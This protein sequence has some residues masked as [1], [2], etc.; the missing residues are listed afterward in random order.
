M[1]S[2]IAVVRLLLDP[3]TEEMAMFKHLLVPIDFSEP[4][5]AA[6]DYART[7]ATQFGASLHLLHVTEDPYRAFYSAE[8]YV[9]EV[10]GLREE[11][12]N[13]SV[14][15]LKGLLRTSDLTDLHAMAEAVIGT[16]ASTI[17]EYAA[18]RGIDLIVMGTH[19]RGG[20]SHLLLGS[21][22]ERVV[23]TAPCPV[24]TVRSVPKPAA[25]SQTK[26]EAAEEVPAAMRASS[27]VDKQC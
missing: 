13:D 22:A 12:L 3:E 25:A 11:I 1:P 21:V 10:E 8:V 23:R 20:M 5:E 14:T 16:P 7:V 26:T 9:P 4:S 19:G 24:L 15:R 18:G 17:T 27:T 2:S 6:L